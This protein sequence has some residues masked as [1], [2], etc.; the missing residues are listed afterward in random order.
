MISKN[1]ILITGT[2]RRVGLYLATEL[3]REGYPI[4]AHYR[5]M[6]DELSQVVSKEGVTAIQ[7]ELD[8]EEGILG[9]INQVKASTGA[10]RAI[11]HNAS[12]YERTNRAD[13]TEAIKQYEVFFWVH[14]VAPYLIN[15]KLQGLLR[16]SEEYA[17]IIHITDIYADRPNPEYD[18]YCSTKAGLANLNKSFA[19]RFAPKIQVNAIAPGP[20][21]FLNSHTEEERARVMAK[22]P[23]QVE[24]GPHAILLA[25]RS[26]LEHHYMTGVTVPVDGGRSLAE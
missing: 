10:L 25:V 12:T 17:D 3:H 1:P 13:V 5:T 6:T 20:I 7:A 21:L 24:G 4:I 11:I 23:L 8:T 14:M 19:K 2:S 9:L 18:I 15:E 16:A 26:L 22:T